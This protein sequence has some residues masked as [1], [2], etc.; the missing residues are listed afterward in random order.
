[1]FLFPRAHNIT[2]EDSNGQ[3]HKNNVPDNFGHPD[4]VVEYRGGMMLTTELILL[5]ATLLVVG[6]RLFTRVRIMGSVHSDDWWILLATGVL[7]ALTTVHCVGESV[8]WPGEG[9]S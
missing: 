8:I 5:G 3:T 7:I 6:L 4:Y 9:W 2:A 1:M